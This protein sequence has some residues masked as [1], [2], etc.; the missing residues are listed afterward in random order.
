MGNCTYT[1]C[2]GTTDRNNGTYS[3][4]SLACH[5][6][7]HYTV[8][9]CIYSYTSLPHVCCVLLVCTIYMNAVCFSSQDFIEVR[10]FEKELETMEQ[11]EYETHDDVLVLIECI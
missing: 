2:T 10:K 5:T 8:P 4:Q 7:N 11:P 3:S 9:L 6:G 1:Y